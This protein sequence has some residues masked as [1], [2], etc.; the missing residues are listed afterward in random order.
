MTESFCQQSAITV[1][2]I[3]SRLFPANDIVSLH[4]YPCIIIILL[5]CAVRGRALFL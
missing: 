4:A 2:V 1:Q 3:A 5:Q